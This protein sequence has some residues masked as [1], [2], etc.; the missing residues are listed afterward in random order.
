MSREALSSGWSLTG[1]YAELD[2]LQQALNKQLGFI[3]PLIPPRDVLATNLFPLE[4]YL[5]KLLEEERL[6]DRRDVGEFFDF[7]SDEIASFVPDVIDRT[8]RTI[9][10]SAWGRLGEDLICQSLE[11]MKLGADEGSPHVVRQVN[12]EEPENVNQ[13]A[14]VAGGVVGFFLGGPFGALLGG[15]LG[16]LAG[17]SHGV[18]ME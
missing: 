13:G 3:L 11:V 10:V 15:T 1:R 12:G 6:A 2:E 9:L 18:S 16:S 17:E 4:V 8:G 14:A 7:P 5:N